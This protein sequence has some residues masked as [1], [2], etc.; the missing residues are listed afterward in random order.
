MTTEDPSAC[1]ASGRNVPVDGRT[2]SEI[3]DRVHEPF[4]SVIIPT[5]NRAAFIGKA[6]QSVIDQTFQDWE[7]IIVD[8]ASEDDTPSVLSSFHDNRISIIRN[9]I[10]IERSASRNRGIGMARGRY[11]CFL[12]SDDLFLADH[13][14]NLWKHIE[15]SEDK[16]ALFA[17]SV[18]KRSSGG[19]TYIDM[20]RRPELSP[21]EQVIRHHIPCISVAVPRDILAK[22]Q[23]NPS[24]R[25]N[26]DVE[27]FARIAARFPVHYLSERTVVWTMHD[28]NTKGTT[29]DYMTPQLH[30]MRTM[31]CNP[32]LR[33]HVSTAFRRE[34]LAAK[35]RSLAHM[36]IDQR[37]PLPALTAII[38]ASLRQPQ[39][40]ETRSLAGR[41]IYSFIPGGWRMK[42]LRRRRRSMP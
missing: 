21:I 37:R 29:T 42:V 23:F 16:I 34:E 5:Y 39:Q 27:L 20:L 36:L 41:F 10:N 33:P 38:R 31:F 2:C 22:E 40:N 6:V 15:A 26:E 32:V 14:G 19:E 30:A 24:L 8:D 25:I 13:L 17:A 7:L 18:I 28:Q 3:S 12:D 9:P 4:F 1:T 35:Y 11:V